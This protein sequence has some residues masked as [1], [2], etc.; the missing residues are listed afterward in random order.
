MFFA[1]QEAS[2]GP[3]L[4]DAKGLRFPHLEKADATSPPI[5]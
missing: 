2:L 1:A 3:L 4:P 5:P